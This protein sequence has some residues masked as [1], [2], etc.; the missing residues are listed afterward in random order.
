[1]NEIKN[2]IEEQT[3]N[4]TLSNDF[5]VSVSKTFNIKNRVAEPLSSDIDK[6]FENFKK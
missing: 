2:F 1:M 3:F 5:H 4:V 6:Q